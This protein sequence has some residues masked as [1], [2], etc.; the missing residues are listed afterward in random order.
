[1]AGDTVLGVGRNR[2]IA[3]NDSTAHAEVIALRNAGG[4]RC[5]YRLT[6]ATLVVT[7]EPCLMCVGAAVHAR[8][9]RIVF[10]ASDPK[11]GCLGGAF[12]A[13]TLPYLNHRPKVTGG[14]LA[15]ECGA[16][17]KNFFAAR[18]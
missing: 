12:D 11:A 14:V 1:M 7:L 2:S 5:N 6:G 13:L 15:D 17:L 9:E 10:G 4:E 3:D 8:I 18:R 16:Q